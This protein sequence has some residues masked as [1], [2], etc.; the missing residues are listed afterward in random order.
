MSN[1]AQSSAF[2]ARFIHTWGCNHRLEEITGKISLVLST[3]PQQKWSSHHRTNITK[4]LDRTRVALKKHG[5]YSKQQQHKL[6]WSH[7]QIRS[8]PVKGKKE[9]CRQHSVYLL[10]K[11]LADYI[12]KLQP[13]G[14]CLPVALGRARHVPPSSVTSLPQH[15][16]SKLN[17][18]KLCLSSVRYQQRSTK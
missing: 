12:A 14:W 13:Q 6:F 4:P 16:P 10:Y 18:T 7:G 15:Y 9:K 17:G 5:M 11:E 3:P 8:F 2:A 1:N